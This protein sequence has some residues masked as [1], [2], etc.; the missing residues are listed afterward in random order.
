MKLPPNGAGTMRRMFN[1]RLIPDWLL[2][3]AIAV[4]LVLLWIAA[5]VEIVS[6]KDLSVAKKALWIA[7]VIIA[8]YVGV[9]AYYVAR[10]LRP[11]EGK[12]Y[13]ETVPRSSA[14]VEELERLSARQTTD[15]L[16]EDEYLSRKRRLLG[17]A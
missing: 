3:V 11:P 4:P 7:V 2:V 8:N 10:P 1:L 16:P 9:A 13:G 5:L 14:I 15:P 12:R 6:R 17:L